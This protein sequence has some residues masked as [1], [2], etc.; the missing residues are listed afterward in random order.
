MR[1]SNIFIKL[2]YFDKTKVMSF[3]TKDN[4]LIE[5]QNAMW[6]KV[7]N[8]LKKKCLIASH[9]PVHYNRYIKNGIKLHNG[10]TNTEH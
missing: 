4:K 1:M 10:K 3:M 6:N 7:N 8:L 9:E 5:E 2:K